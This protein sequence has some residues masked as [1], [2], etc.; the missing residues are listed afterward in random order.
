[1]VGTTV[2]LHFAA[3]NL[4]PDSLK[5][6]GSQ[7]PD[8]LD[9]VSR[10]LTEG[11]NRG[12]D[13][14]FV[15]GFPLPCFR[16]GCNEWTISGSSRVQDDRYLH[17]QNVFAWHP[18]HAI[19]NLIIAIFAAGVAMLVTQGVCRLAGIKSRQLLASSCNEINQIADETKQAAKSEDGTPPSN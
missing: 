9:A 2:L 15:H 6:G 17:P 1:M 14:K 18:P 12:R 8:N 16:S 10:M 19:E 13:D 3:L 5:P 4:I 11:R 7:W